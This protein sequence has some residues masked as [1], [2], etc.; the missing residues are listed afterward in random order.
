MTI[1][2]IQTWNKVSF[3]MLKLSA[4]PNWLLCVTF[5]INTWYCDDR[6]R[7]YFYSFIYPLNEEISSFFLS[8]LRSFIHLMQRLSLTHSFT[9]PSIYPSIQHK[10]SFIHSIHNVSLPL[11]FP[12]FIVVLFFLHSFIHLI[13]Q[14]RAD[15]FLYLFTHSMQRFHLFFI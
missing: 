12:S 13:S 8:C 5:S 4:L 7:I 9:H 6:S 2:Y 11:P 15:S 1:Q 10:D 14:Y 3:G